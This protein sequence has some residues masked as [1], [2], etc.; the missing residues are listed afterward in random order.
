MSKNSFYFSHDNNARNDEK[1]LAVRME[2]GAEGYGIYFMLLE[3]LLETE[4]YILIKDYNRLAFD[5]RVSSEKIKKVIENFGL[6][7]FTDDGKLFYSESLLRRMQPLDNLR[8]QRSEAGKKSAEKRQ[9]VR[10]N[11]PSLQENSTTAERPLQEN[12]TEKVKESK[13]NVLLEKE[14][15]HKHNNMGESNFSE[16][17]PQTDKPPNAEPSKKVAKKKVSIPSMEEF[18]TYALDYIEQKKIKGTREQWKPTI[19]TKYEAWKDAGWKDGNGKSIANW[20]LKIQST[21]PYLK[22]HYGITDNGNNNYHHAS[23]TQRNAPS[24]NGVAVSKK[25]SAR[26]IL[27]RELAQQNVGNEE[28]RGFG[29]TP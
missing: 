10:E 9:R 14:P 12:S 28:S 1:I 8:K 25:I 5:L 18:T 16:E 27:A 11:T 2:L 13:V 26:A 23:S 20:K 3:K 15:K 21:I 22:P 19:E 17:N 6:F 24:T 4:N 7:Q 29:S